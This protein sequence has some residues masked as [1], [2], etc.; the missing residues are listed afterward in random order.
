M[1]DIQQY[2]ILFHKYILGISQIDKHIEYDIKSNMLGGYK[3]NICHLHIYDLNKFHIFFQNIVNEL[4]K[5]Y[6]IIITYCIGEI[7]N[8]A[9]DVVFLKIRNRG[10]DIGGKICLIDYLYKLQI[11]YEYILFLHSKSDKNKRIRYFSPLVNR[12]NEIN[13]ILEKKEVLGIFPN[14][15]WINHKGIKNYKNYDLYRNNENYL[16]ELLEFIDCKNRIRIFS[17]GNCMILNKKVIDFIFRERCEIFYNI[18]NEEDS[19]D[20]NW[21]ITY[22]KKYIKYQN[23]IDKLRN[24]QQSFIEYRSKAGYGNN[25]GLKGSCSTHPDGMIEHV[26]ERIWIN[27][28][29]ELK[30]KCLILDERNI[31]D[32]DI[33]L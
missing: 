32:L 23:N 5:Y 15:L 10:Y 22:N 24:I 28:I 29:I 20:Y 1:I 11:D 16:D 27:S 14:T 33:F 3:K 19:F 2:P 26:F 12:L 25:N 18:L 13:S 9:L 17:E 4:D 21:Y 7:K 31:I 8:I 30:G 6:T